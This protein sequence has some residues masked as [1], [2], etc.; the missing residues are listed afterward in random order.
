MTN[1]IVYIVIIFIIVMKEIYYQWKFIITII[2][3]EMFRGLI[4]VLT[5]FV[6]CIE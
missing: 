1:F 4:E 2:E 6:V 3:I 5:M